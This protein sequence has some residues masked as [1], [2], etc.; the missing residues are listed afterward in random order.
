L[1][2]FIPG[3]QRASRRFRGARALVLAAV[4]LG[5]AG[6]IV[7]Q[8]A[9]AA[10]AMRVVIVV[11]PTEAGTGHNIADAKQLA[12]QA[13]GY[14]ATVIEIYSPNATWPRVR[15]AAQ[16]ANV[17]IY[18]GH[19]SGWPSPYTPFTTKKADGLGLNAVAGH[20]NANVTYY[21]EWYL[22]HYIRLAPNA[23]V[24]LRGLCYSAGNSE[25]GKPNPTVAVGKARVDNFAA[26][27]LR[28]GAKAVF[29]EPYG[30]IGYILDAIFTSDLSASQIFASGNNRG[31]GSSQ[32]LISVTFQSVRTGFA[33]V[34]SERET[35]GRFR[36]SVVGILDLTATSV[37]LPGS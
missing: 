15:S 7:A 20:G 11:G 27:F 16:G 13:R 1:N 33:T 4:L 9:V 22:A 21:G 24:L 36:R 31:R 19:G 23:V 32:A 10:T 37:R 26:G 14:G 25:P 35:S 17:F 2:L 18:M 3:A 8:P 12:A 6:S 34:I 5:L 30:G 29:A 28:T